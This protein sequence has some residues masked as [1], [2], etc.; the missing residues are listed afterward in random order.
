MPHPFQL[1]LCDSVR[2]CKT[3]IS[4]DSGK[5]GKSGKHDIDENVVFLFHP[6]LLPD[7][8]ISNTYVIKSVH[9]NKYYFEL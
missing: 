4:I 9:F 6:A 5:S 3:N 8:L 7:I 1:I 2:G